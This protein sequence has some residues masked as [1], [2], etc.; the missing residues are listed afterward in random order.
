MSPIL[1][2]QNTP[3]LCS[4]KQLHVGNK[5]MLIN[6][7]VNE[8]PH[9]LTRFMYILQAVLPARACEMINKTFWS[10]RIRTIS[11]SQWPCHILDEI[12][13]RQHEIT[14]LKQVCFYY[15]LLGTRLEI[16]I[17]TPLGKPRPFRTYIF[18]RIPI[19]NFV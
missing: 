11:G 16:A 15:V 7:S 14:K 6:P 19:R 1:I 17:Y 18:L 5:N 10:L 2:F 13:R 12:K 9:I 3:F 8:F 4:S